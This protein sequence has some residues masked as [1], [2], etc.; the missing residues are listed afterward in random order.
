MSNQVLGFEQI[1]D[2]VV[3]QRAGKLHVIASQMDNLNNLMKQTGAI[4]NMASHTEAMQAM[5]AAL[6]PPIRTLSRY[7][8]WTQEFFLH[9]SFELGEDNRVALDSPLGSAF[10]SSPG[11][12]V[13]YVTPGVQRYARPTFVE[14][15]GG[16]FINWSTMEYAKWNVLQRRLE[17]TADAM[18]QKKDKIAQP[19]LDTAISS[20]SHNT[21]C[22]T[23][24]TKAAVDYIIKQSAGIGFPVT[25][26]AVN[27]A[28][29]MDMTAW[30]NGST[31]ALPVFFSPESAREQV[32]QQ[33]WFSGY[34]N[35]RYFVSKDVPA[36]MVY[37]GGEP[38]ETGYIQTH[39]AVRSVSDMVVQDKGD[40]HL[41]WEDFAA[42]VSNIY[43]LWSI[44]IT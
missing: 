8:S 40:L 13:E 26:V 33:L 19:V 27:P 25:H 15:D 34:G 38:A 28:T 2:P 10:L 11:G 37:F 3:M 35:L 36:T 22:S 1:L 42:Y 29:I 31:S 24:L 9:Q 4:S 18:A 43:N 23:S 32:Y 41:Y 39:G 6:L 20:A 16:V 30:T 17:E 21:T 14:I 5:G 12:R 7:K 44:Q